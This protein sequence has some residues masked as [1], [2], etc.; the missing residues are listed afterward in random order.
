MARFI[1]VQY[2]KTINLDV[3]VGVLLPKGVEG[4]SKVVKA[5]KKPKKPEQ[6]KSVP[7]Q[8][9]KDVMKPVQESVEK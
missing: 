8:I 7:M 4:T 3:Q 9:E 1:D 2:L 5:S 6:P